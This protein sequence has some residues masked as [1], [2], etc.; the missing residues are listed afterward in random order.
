MIWYDI[1]LHVRHGSHTQHRYDIKMNEKELTKLLNTK[2]KKV[3]SIAPIKLIEIMEI[4]LVTTTKNEMYKS[5]DAKEKKSVVE[6][7]RAKI[8]R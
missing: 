2:E 8:R 3:N 6:K 5:Y 1:E 4:N 7:E